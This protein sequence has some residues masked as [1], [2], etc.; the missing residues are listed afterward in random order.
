MGKCTCTGGATCWVNGVR[1][2]RDSKARKRGRKL[3]QTAE[4]H[5]SGTQGWWVHIHLASATASQAHTQS[6]T[7]AVLAL[8]GEGGKVA[9]LSLLDSLTA[10]RVEQWP[11]VTGVGA[12]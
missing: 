4:A 1:K 7:L 9:I 8:V 3:S 6:G 5:T 12:I 10:L 11:K 2:Q